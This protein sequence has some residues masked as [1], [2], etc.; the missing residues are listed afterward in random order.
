MK[1]ELEQILE[2]EDV[3]DRLREEL[4]ELERDS[5]KEA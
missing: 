2:K 3:L 1:R 5:P 4:R